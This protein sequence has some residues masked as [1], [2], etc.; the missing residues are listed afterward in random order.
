MSQP[1]IGEIRMVG[2]SFAPAGW[3]MCN[4]QLMP[5]S[6]ND[7]LFVLLG[8]SWGGDGQETFGL[9]NMQSRFP[10]HAG[11]GFNFSEMAGVESVTLTAQT[12]P[13]H[14]HVPTGINGDGNQGTPLN[15]V[16]AASN[17]RQFSTSA[18]NGVLATNCLL[19]NTQGGQPHENMSPYAV[20]TFILSLFGVFPSPT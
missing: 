6:Q 15:S 16:W 12:I 13:T 1:Y 9:P 8:T 3:A 2:F 19:P 11:N 14:S 18:P 10:M 5:I 20:V 7:A 4:G 17:A